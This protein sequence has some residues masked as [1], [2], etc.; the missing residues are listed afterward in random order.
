MP[1]ALS[2]FPSPTNTNTLANH[3]GS[4]EI[5][6]SKPAQLLSLDAHPTAS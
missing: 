3:R 5:Q 6:L 2:P 1:V 4:Q